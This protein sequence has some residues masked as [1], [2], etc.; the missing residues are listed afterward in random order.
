MLA[1]AYDRKGLHDQA[2]EWWLKSLLS[3]GVSRETIETLRTTYAES[4]FEGYW[5]KQV[6]LWKEQKDYHGLG[7][8]LAL[9][10]LRSGDKESAMQCLEKA[11]VENDLNLVLIKINPWMDPLRSDPRFHALLKKMNL[12]K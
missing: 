9:G 12:D 2:V 11:Y 3:N 4:G 8:M 10:Y 5:R 6:E 1:D 7:F